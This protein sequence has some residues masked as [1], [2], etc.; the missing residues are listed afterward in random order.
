MFTFKDTKVEKPYEHIC[1]HTS[2][3]A[4]MSIYTHTDDNLLWWCYSIFFI[5]FQVMLKWYREST[6]NLFST[7]SLISS[8]LMPPSISL[9]MKILKMNDLQKICYCIL[10]VIHFLN[11]LEAKWLYQT[12]QMT[13][14]HF[15]YSQTIVNSNDSG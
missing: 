3:Y 14:R 15:Y 4:C 10:R 12:S 7:I 13:S 9:E 1:I 8:W 6:R 5:Y 11:F 2:V